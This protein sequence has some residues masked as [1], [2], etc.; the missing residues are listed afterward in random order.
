MT[1]IETPVAILAGGR[2]TRLGEL[3]EQQPKALLSVA[4]EPFVFHQLRQLHE[5]G[6]T[7][8]V[9]CIGHRGDQIREAVGD[10]TDHGLR[11]RYSEDP[12]GLAGTAGALRVALPLLGEGFLLLYGDTYL[13]IDFADVERSFRASGLEGLLTVLRN[14]GRWDTSN[15]AV[16]DGH[17]VRHDK[18]R[19]DPDMEWID[20]GLGALRAEALERAPGSSDLTDVYAELAEAG[21]LAAYPA[22]HRFHEIGTPQALAETDAYLRAERRQYPRRP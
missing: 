5:H 11:V 4:G 1:P 21:Q 22:L 2:A 20:Y 19:P 3:A 6:F 17:V 14:E 9:L 13:E 15:T 16:E 8:V 7:D 12:P 10:G 18:R